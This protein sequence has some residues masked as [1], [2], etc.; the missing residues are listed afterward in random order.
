VTAATKEVVDNTSGLLSGGN[1][2]TILLI[3]VLLGGAA[4]VMRERWMKARDW[5]I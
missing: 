4:W 2:I 3:L 5:D 1:V